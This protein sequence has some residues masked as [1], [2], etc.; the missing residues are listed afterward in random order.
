MGWT[1]RAKSTFVEAGGGSVETSTCADEASTTLNSSPDAA[2]PDRL[3]LASG[4]FTF[5]SGRILSRAGP[6]RHWKIS[7]LGQRLNPADPTCPIDP[8]DPSCAQA[9][10]FG[11]GGAAGCSGGGAWSTGS[12]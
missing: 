4:N 3:I 2:N 1:S 12:G 7:A 6:S 5:C 9:S 8:T 11:P 10:G